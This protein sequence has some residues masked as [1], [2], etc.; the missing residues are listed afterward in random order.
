MKTRSIMSSNMCLWGW[1]SGL[2]VLCSTPA[3]AAG[4]ATSLTPGEEVG[5]VTSDREQE[6]EIA[7]SVVFVEADAATWGT[8]LP[9]GGLRPQFSAGGLGVLDENGAVRLQLGAEP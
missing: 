8:I 3:R 7:R 2:V 1:V 6:R 9:A 5:A 4:Q